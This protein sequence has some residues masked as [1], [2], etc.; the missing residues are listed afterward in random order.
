MHSGLPRVTTLSFGGFTSVQAILPRQVWRKLYN[1]F[2]S[3]TS[4]LP[5]TF[6]S[7][8]LPILA[9]VFCIRALFVDHDFCA[10]RSSL[11]NEAVFSHVRDAR[12]LFLIL[13]SSFF[14]HGNGAFREWVGLLRIHGENNRKNVF[15]AT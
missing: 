11:R 4:A 7:S 12:T 15:L 8:L 3:P 6:L 13:D 1:S 10:L 14:S 2:S 9:C 5:V